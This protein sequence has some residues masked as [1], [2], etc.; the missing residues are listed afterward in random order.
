MTAAELLD[1]IKELLE[2]AES[3]GA[4]WFNVELS[5]EP[6]PADFSPLKRD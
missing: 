4:K 6:L 1:G 3:K 2:E 5:V